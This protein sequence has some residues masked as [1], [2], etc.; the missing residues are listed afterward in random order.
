MRVPKLDTIANILIVAAALTVLGGSARS[1]LVSAITPPPPPPP[2]PIGA[3]TVG[4]R[5]AP[6]V[7][8]VFDDQT[9]LLVTRSSCAFCARSMPLYQEMKRRGARIIAVAAEDVEVNR[10]YLAANG[11]VADAVVTLAESGLTIQSVPA[12]LSV[13]SR[14]TVTG[15]WWG[16]QTQEQEDG[17]LRRIGQ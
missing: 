10:A 3:Y 6:I 8:I 2:E 17:I 9:F 13:D 11:V 5:L 1:W 7:G 12:L 4:D 15:A 16:V 14:G